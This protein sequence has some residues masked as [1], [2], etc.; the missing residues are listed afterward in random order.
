MGR[1]RKLQDGVT[2]FAQIE[3]K[4]HEA[5]RRLAFKEHS[6]M[7]ELTREAIDMLITQRKGRRSSRT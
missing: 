1:P 6:S 3:Q 4:Q 2:L 5:L 7:A